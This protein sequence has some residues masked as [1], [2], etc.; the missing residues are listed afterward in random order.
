[1]KQPRKAARAHGLL[2]GALHLMA[3]QKVAE[4]GR[5]HYGGHQ[6]PLHFDFSATGVVVLDVDPTNAAPPKISSVPS[7][8]WPVTVSCRN[9][10]PMNTA[11]TYPIAVTGRT[12]LR[13][14]RLSRAI[15]VNRAKISAAIPIAT[16]G[17]NMAR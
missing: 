6:N 17:S 10:F 12:K 1:M 5:D 3:L 8:R 2:A 4:H 9:T 7:Q 11:I 14:A 13:S 16:N 15:R